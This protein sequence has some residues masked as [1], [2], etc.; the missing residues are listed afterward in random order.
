[1]IK[2]EVIENFT[3]AKFNELKN[4]DRLGGGKDDFFKVRDRFE[5]TD[6]MA[7]Y[8]TGDNDQKKVVVK[9]LEVIPNED[10]KEELPTTEEIDKAYEEIEK[11]PRKK[12]TSKK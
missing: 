6:E 12:R 5:C 4:V 9:V 10:V 1:M 11:K 3:L 2:C 8:L 7:K